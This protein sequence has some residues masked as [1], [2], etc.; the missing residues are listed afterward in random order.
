MIPSSCK[1]ISEFRSLGPVATDFGKRLAQ[2]RHHAHL[3]QEQL[4]KRAGLAQSTLAAA[5]SVGHGSRRTAQLAAACGVNPHWLATGEGA[6]LE[7]GP[8]MSMA[9]PAPAY[10][11]DRP[12]A[13]VAQLGHMLQ[14]HS[15]Q[16]R[17]T[18]GGIL[19]RFA[20]APEN[21]ELAAELALLIRK[22]AD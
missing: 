5:E 15:A 14:S 6:M 4:A 1:A 19:A 13:L 21:A 20:E 7:T 22:P 12:A 10:A 11:I 3:T 2:A 18:L 16:R 8:R 17:S 9:E